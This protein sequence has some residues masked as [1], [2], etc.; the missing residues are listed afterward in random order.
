MTPDLN[1]LVRLVR[2][3]ASMQS[4]LVQ[5]EEFEREAPFYHLQTLFYQLSDSCEALEQA[6]SLLTQAA[7][8][9]AQ[10]DA[11]DLTK[12]SLELAIDMLRA[13]SEAIASDST[14]LRIGKEESLLLAH[15][16][17]RP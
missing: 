4:L 14:S 13:D 1:Y 9:I 2:L 8:L 16:H 17:S 11:H 5:I 3:K 15:P 6:K 7:H 10:I 12:S